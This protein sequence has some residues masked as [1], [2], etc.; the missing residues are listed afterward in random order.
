MDTNDTLFEDGNM[1]DGHIE[2]IFHP[3]SIQMVEVIFR[4]YQLREWFTTYQIFNG[5]IYA[6]S[7]GLF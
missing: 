4:C 7:V 2:C 1:Y 5:F 3:H 6:G